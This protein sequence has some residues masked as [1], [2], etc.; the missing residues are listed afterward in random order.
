MAEAAAVEVTVELGAA[1]LSHG[2][3]VSIAVCSEGELES[4][5]QGSVIGDKEII[6]YTK[7]RV[8]TKY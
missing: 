7:T 5:G 1:G 6:T 4:A 8:Q 3:D 2:E